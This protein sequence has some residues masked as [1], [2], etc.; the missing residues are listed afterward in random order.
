MNRVKITK[1]MY[2]KEKMYKWLVILCWLTIL[3]CTILKMFGSKQFEMPNYT[4]NISD[5]TQK[6]VNYIFYILNSILFAM[7]LKKDKL[8]LKEIGVVVLLYTPLFIMSM[9]P[10]IATIRFILETIMFF[11]LG[12]IIIKD[13]WW[14]VLLE[15]ISINFIIIIYQLITMLYKNINVKIKIDNFIVSY[16]VLIDYY[17][18]ILLTYL[19]IKKK[20]EYIYGQW[21]KFLVVLSNKRRNEKC[22]QQSDVN[23]QKESVKKQSNEVGFTLFTLILSLFQ[24]S[25]V[26]TLCYF[27]NNTTWQ[28]VIIFVTFC[29]LRAI[30][31]KSYHCN[32][33]IGCTSLSCLVFVIATKLS[34]PPYIS[35]LC[36]VLIGLL[37]AYMMFI[38]YYY[39]KHTN[40]KG[41]TLSRGM[42]LEAL[43]EM[44]SNLQLSDIEFNILVDFYVKRKSLQNIAMKIGYSQINVSK[45]KSKAIKKIIG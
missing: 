38:M 9:F 1:Q 30:F 12:K 36:N 25:L 7:L 45:I 20:G 16:I 4:Y 5:T 40:S 6:I 19:Y 8:T 41:I 2:D 23:L 3:T 24:F 37:I 13:K 27:I 31:G 42:S 29:V 21:S 28:F 14:K 32:T 26:F 39:D 35:T 17:T 43:T 15:V 33:I 34:L 10:K 44:C 22:V 18:L 11:V